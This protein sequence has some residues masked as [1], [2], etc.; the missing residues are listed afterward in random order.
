MVF[1]TNPIG[2]PSL[3]S[4]PIWTAL[5]NEEISTFREFW[6]DTFLKLYLSLSYHFGTWSHFFFYRDR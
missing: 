2:Q 4:F 5:I 6:S 1:L 3:E